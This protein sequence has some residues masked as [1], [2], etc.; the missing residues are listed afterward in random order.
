VSEANTNIEGKKAGTQLD[1]A[2][3]LRKACPRHLSYT[4]CQELSVQLAA[5]LLKEYDI[6]QVRQFHYVAIPRG[7]F[8][9]L[10]YLSYLLDIPAQQFKC[11][12]NNTPLIIVDDTSISGS[13]FKQYLAKVTSKE[14]VFV[15]LYS[16]PQLR[17]AILE[18]EERVT[19]C[20]AVRDLKDLATEIYSAPGAYEAWRKRWGK[21]LPDRYWI[22]LPEHI[23]FPWSEPDR[24]YWNSETEQV[25]DCWRLAPPDQCLKN[26]ARLGLPPKTTARRRWR[27]PA[28]LAH[29]VSGEQVILVDLLTDKV[30]CFEGVSA[31]MWLALAAYGDLDGVIAHIENL[32]D[33]KG[34]ELQTDLSTFIEELLENKLLESV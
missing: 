8:F 10:G 27:S 18:N 7:G 33:V 16:S 25:S 12:N 4:E 34:P 29:S 32:Y 13:R 9:I 20:I 2:I 14:V 1:G 30:F 31:Q 11:D 19:A 23:S 5:Q 6:D 26:W 21:R 17:K 15:H 3:A 28:N 22:G 24:T